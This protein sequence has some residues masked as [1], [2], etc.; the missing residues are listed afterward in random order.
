VDLRRYWVEKGWPDDAT[1]IARLAE[2]P[3][4]IREKKKCRLLLER[5]ESEQGQREAVNPANLSI[6][7]VLPQTVENDEAGRSWQAALGLSWAQEHDKWMHALGN[8]T[9]TGTNPEL[10]NNTFAA[11]R[12]I[13]ARSN[14]SLNA[15]FA[16]VPDWNG[17][18]IKNRGIELGRFIVRVWPR[19]DGAPYVPMSS[20]AADIFENLGVEP[21]APRSEQPATHGRLRDVIH[22]SLLGQNEINDPEV[23]QEP[24][25]ALTHAKLIGRL[26][27]VWGPTMSERL[28]QIPVARGDSFSLSPN[29]E[30]DFINAAQGTVFNHKLVPGTHLY[31]FTN[32]DKNRKVQDILLLVRRLGF[33]P[34]SIEAS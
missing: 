19:P 18:E 6:E 21:P 23:I 7:H 11:K 14:V 28:Q 3:I 30:R 29:P 27:E 33:P 5:L 10:G 2:F 8:L 32:T 4:Y 34:G 13:F 16:N 20:P 26:I 25:D 1:F 31:I 17:L 24:K 22:W 9:L 15:Y 12:A